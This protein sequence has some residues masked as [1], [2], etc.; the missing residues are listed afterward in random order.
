M[1]DLST[2]PADEERKTSKQ[3]RRKSGNR[4]PFE[5]RILAG[6]IAFVTL[7]FALNILLNDEIVFVGRRASWLRSGTPTVHLHGWP[8]YWCFLTLANTALIF[9]TFIFDHYDRRFNP[10]FYVWLRRALLVVT[11]VF[12]IVGIGVSF[13]EISRN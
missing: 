8:T 4:V 6:F 9:L 2:K 3:L 10:N 12:L 13:A 11:L 5:E 1:S 7:A